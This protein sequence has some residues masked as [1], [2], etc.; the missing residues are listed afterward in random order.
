MTSNLLFL[1][2]THFKEFAA[3]S[4]CLLASQSIMAN[5][6]F[7]LKCLNHFNTLSA[8]KP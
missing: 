2:E 3:D 4:N 1:T 7:K 8:I 6:F 5:S